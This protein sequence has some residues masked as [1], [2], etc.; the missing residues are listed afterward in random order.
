MSTFHY[1]AALGI[2]ITFPSLTQS[3][4]MS[5]MHIPLH[6]LCPSGHGAVVNIAVKITAHHRGPL[7]YH[8]TT[9]GV[10]A[11]MQHKL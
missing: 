2:K 7:N 9:S 10:I 5:G 6:L 3:L 11:A 8:I 1:S 4:S